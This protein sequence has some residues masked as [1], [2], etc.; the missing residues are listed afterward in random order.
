MLLPYFECVRFH[1]IDLMH[2]LFTGTAKHV[3]KNIWL[4]SDKPLLEK[5]NLLHIQEKLDRLKVPANVGRIPK[6]IQNSYGGFTADQWKSFTVLFSIYALRILPTSDLELWRDFVMARSCL[7]SPLVTE[8]K[9]MLAHSYLLKFC[10]SFEELY[11]KDKVT[12]NMH[13]HTHLVDCVLD[14]GLVSA[15]W[16]F[17]FERY[18]GILGEF[19]TDQQLMRTFTSIQFVQDVPLPTVFQDVLKPVLDKLVSNQAR[20]LQDQSLDQDNLS[21]RVIHTCRLSTGPVQKRN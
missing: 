2:N 14:Y 4:D 20:S 11:G 9:A 16:L 6:K 13:L 3:I 18:N 19:G 10:Q 12:P 17:S 8:T 5:K 21:A 15:F 1:I 7:C